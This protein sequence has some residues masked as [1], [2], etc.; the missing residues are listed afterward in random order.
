MKFLYLLLGLVCVSSTNA[1]TFISLTHGDTRL[2]DQGS[3]L[4]TNGSFEGHVLF[5]QWAQG[6]PPAGWTSS[7]SVANYA[8]YTDPS[9]GKPYSF[10]ADG[11]NSLYFGNSQT[12]AAPIPTLDYSTGLASTSS[13]FPNYGL[14]VEVSQTISGL[15]PA[16][17]YMIDFYAS[18]ERSSGSPSHPDGA[19]RTTIGANS[20]DLICPNVGAFGTSERYQFRFIPNSGSINLSFTNFGH[21]DMG[22]GVFAVELVL[23]DVIMNRLYT[24]SGSVWDDI[25]ASG[26]IA[27]N[28]GETY[29]TLPTLYTKII[30]G[31]VVIGVKAFSSGNYSF[32]EGFAPGAYSVIIDDNDSP[33]DMTPTLPA[34]WIIPFRVY[35]S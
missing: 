21:I 2:G 20:F 16:G 25:D 27:P 14:P 11:N 33:S 7:G 18:H 3:N 8:Y 19:F 12:I 28:G 5:D 17:I 26:S 13:Y 23:D 4:I 24:V 34:G 15:D 30:K 35:I 10:I 22:G 6:T 29:T 9:W 32:T 31:G 1:Q